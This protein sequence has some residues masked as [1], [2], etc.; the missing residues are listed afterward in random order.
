M[1]DQAT[2][3][4]PAEPLPRR[5]FTAAEVFTMLEAGVLSEDEKIELIDGDIVPMAPQSAPHMF[6]KTKLNRLFAKSLPPQLC[7][8]VEPTLWM[9]DGSLFDP[10]LVIAPDMP[11]PSKLDPAAVLLLIEVA[12]SSLARDLAVKAPRYAAAGIAEYWVVEA[13]TR[14]T[15]RLRDPAADGSWARM[16]RV[17]PDEHLAAERLP[18]LSLSMGAL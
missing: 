16:D 17:A 15:H 11:T 1:A 10:D 7:V 9:P 18:S 6:I 3:A 8:Y 13:E 14:V 12:A 5:R 4:P 2:L